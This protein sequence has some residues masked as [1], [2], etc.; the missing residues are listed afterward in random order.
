MSQ[1]ILGAARERAAL[2]EA[3][4]LAVAQIARSGPLVFA[5]DDLPLLDT[6]TL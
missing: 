1:S 2:V 5:I 4:V 3:I 6:S